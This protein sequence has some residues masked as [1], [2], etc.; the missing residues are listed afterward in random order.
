MARFGQG[1]DPQ[2]A[3]AAKLPDFVSR[4]KG[5]VD[6][7]GPNPGKPWRQGETASDPYYIIRRSILLRS[8][9]ERNAQQLFVQRDGKRLLQIDPGVLRAFLRVRAFRHGI[10]SMESVVAMSQLSGKTAYERSSL[11]SEAQL[12]LHVDGQ[13]FL[14][15]VQ[16]IDVEGEL[17]EKLAEATHEVF[18]GHTSR[19]AYADLSEEDKEQNR[20]FVRDIPD[21][22][23]RIGYAMIPARSNEPPFEFPPGR[24]LV[25][26]L[27]RM[28]HERW[29]AAKLDAGWRPGPVTD[30]DRRIHACIAPWE[31]LPAAE[32]E[33]DEVL[34]KAI[35]RILAK[36]GYTVVALRNDPAQRT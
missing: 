18:R 33:K 25:E 30:R 2:T 31:N 19:E 1:L 6:V 36:A 8:I 23:A 27:A 29:M 20:S 3:R 10:R 24:H 11:P 16:Q 9:L 14:A 7:L 15:L 26:M 4:L 5:Y 22:L 17:L 28:E 13:E 35:P 12:D 21:K 32:K 34:V